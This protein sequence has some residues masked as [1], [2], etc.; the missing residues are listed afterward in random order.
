MTLY[1][2]KEP[3]QHCL[4]KVDDTVCHR[5]HVTP[6]FENFKCCSFLIRLFAIRYLLESLA[7]FK[8]LGVNRP[9]NQS[10]SHSFSFEEWACQEDIFAKRGR[11]C[12]E[13]P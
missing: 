3:S 6:L 10:L 9:Q 7:R 13:F 2:S 8:W 11:E 4:P 12:F 5:N 1:K